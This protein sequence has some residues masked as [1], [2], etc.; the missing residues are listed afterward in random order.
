VVRGTE[1][2]VS[3]VGAVVGLDVARSVED[4][5]LDLV[6]AQAQ[7]LARLRHG[8]VELRNVGVHCSTSVTAMSAVRVAWA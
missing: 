4:L 2:V 8:V 1:D 7:R 3:A 6:S 5:V